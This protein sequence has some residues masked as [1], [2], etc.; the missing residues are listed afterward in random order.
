MSVWDWVECGLIDHDKSIPAMGGSFGVT[1]GDAVGGFF[2]AR[3]THIFGPDIKL[4]ADPEDMLMGKLESVLPGVAQLLA[5]IGGN[6]TF[7]YG[8]NVTATYIGPKME[9]RRAHA[10]SKTS[11]Y[12]LPRIKAAGPAS[13]A[14]VPPVDPI[15]PAMLAAVAALSVLII[16][17]PAALELAIRFAYPLYGSKAAG[18]QEAVEG[19]GKAPEIMKLC[20]YM[21]TSRLMGFLKM[22]E[23]KGSWAQFAE[24][25]VKEAEY[26]GLRL[27][28]LAMLAIPVYGFYGVL[29]WRSEFALDESLASTAAALTEE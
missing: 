28:V 27:A 14:G 20:A 17:V 24:Q 22:L 29:V 5:G 4:V 21:V 12:V 1:I 11:D 13:A 25:W 6:V 8:S 16:C 10:V 2:G 7:C 23:E 3:H 15:D 19:Y 9:I 18:D 26:L